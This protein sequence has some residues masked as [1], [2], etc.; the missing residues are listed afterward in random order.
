[1]I[2]DGR[3]PQDSLAERVLGPGDLRTGVHFF[4]TKKQHHGL[5]EHPYVHPLR[6][7]HD[8]VKIAKYRSGGSPALPVASAHSCPAFPVVLSHS[9]GSVPA[10]AHVVEPPRVAARQMWRVGRYWRPIPRIARRNT[11]PN[12]GLQIVE[13][14]TRDHVDVPGLEVATRWR[15]QGCAEDSPQQIGRHR[16]IEKTPYGL[17]RTHRFVDVH[18]DNH[19]PMGRDLPQ[20]WAQRATVQVGLPGLARALAT[21]ARWS[22]RIR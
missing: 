9:D 17:A 11:S 20:P 1:V 7:K 2:T 4:G 10:R 14:R 15:L 21:A 18:Y 3:V 5:Q 12:L 22:A 19:A 13:F 8:F 16:A 6:R